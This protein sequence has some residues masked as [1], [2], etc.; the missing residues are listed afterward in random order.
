MFTRQHGSSVE[1]DGTVYYQRRRGTR[2]G[3]GAQLV[4]YPLGGPAQVLHDYPA[5]TDGR[6]TVLDPPAMGPKL[7]FTKRN[8]STFLRSS[9]QG[10][11]RSLRAA[12]GAQPVSWRRRSAHDRNYVHPQQQVQESFRPRRVPAQIARDVLRAAIDDLATGTQAPSP[13]G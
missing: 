4:M 1:A 7:N 2:C 8:I 11:A 3:N 9:G 12:T 5:G 10:Q 13:T 6:R